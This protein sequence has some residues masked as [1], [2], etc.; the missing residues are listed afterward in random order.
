MASEPLELLLNLVE[1]L[2]IDQKP[3]LADL[4]TLAYRSR[5][6]SQAKEDTSRTDDYRFNYADLSLKRPIEEYSRG[7]SRIRLEKKDGKFSLKV[8]NIIWN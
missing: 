4:L 1:A 2:D 6:V 8:L 5:Q 3:Q 7:T